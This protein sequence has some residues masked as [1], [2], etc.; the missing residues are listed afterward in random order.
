MTTVV[1]FTGYA[2]AG[3]D[4]FAD[5][6]KA[7]LVRRNLKVKSLDYATPIR[8]I[9]AKLGL[10]PYERDRKEVPATLHFEHF[11]LELADAISE[12]LQY[13]V[14]ADDLAELFA[15]TATILRAGGYVDAQQRLTISPRR[16]C[17][18]LGTEGGRKVRDTF[19]IDVYRARCAAYGDTLDVVFCPAVRFPNERTPLDLLIGVN[20]PEVVPVEAHE[21]EAYIGQLIDE[22]DIVFDNVAGLTELHAEA[23][24]LADFIEAGR[25]HGNVA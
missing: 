15:H 13:V 10:R 5:A 24:S 4:T 20:R 12:E 21:S 9:A 23:K 14:G 2:G 11:E 8:E 19:W 16:F 7:Q 25:G 17:Q 18:L 22:A 3:K 1:G 6:V